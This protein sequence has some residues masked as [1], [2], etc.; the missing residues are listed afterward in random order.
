MNGSKSLEKYGKLKQANR[1]VRILSIVI[2]D[3]YR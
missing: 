2:V 3:I 1:K